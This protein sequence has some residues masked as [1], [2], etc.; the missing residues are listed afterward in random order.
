MP[1]DRQTQREAP[2]AEWARPFERIANARWFNNTMTGVI[3]LASI[4]VGVQ[5]YKDINEQYGHLL[6]LLD[7]IIIGVFVVELVI[8]M[9]AHGWRPWRF[10]LNGWNVFDFIVVVICL[11]P[12]GREFGAVLRLAR[13]LRALRLFSAI[14]RLQVMV[15]ALI[16]SIPSI[17]YVGL[18]LFLHFYVYAVVGVVLFGK[19]DPVYFGTVHDAMLALF[20]VVTQEDW[21]DVWYIQMRGSDVYNY[22]YE[23]D[24]LLKGMQDRIREPKAQPIIATIYFISFVITATFIILNLF[25]GVVLSGMDEAQ[26]EQAAAAILRRGGRGGVTEKLQNLE[27]K[28]ERTLAEIS[29]LRRA[30]AQADVADAKAV[31]SNSKRPTDST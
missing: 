16:R 19:N 8:R 4:L 1:A 26:K 27:T 7:S 15:T 28:L 25:I 29:D 10:F 11:I 13:V 9:A 5:T 31:K 6:S 12:F 14:P 23:R 2:L 3:V 22:D 24:V 30:L 20:R 21:T 17:G 18:L